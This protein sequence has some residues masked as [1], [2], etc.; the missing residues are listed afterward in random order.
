MKMP[1]KNRE[2]EAS[3]LQ[4]G[5]PY[6]DASAA[7]SDRHSNV[8]FTW[9]RPDASGIQELGVVIGWQGRSITGHLLSWT[10]TEDGVELP[11]SFVSRNYQPDRVLETNNSTDLELEVIA[12]FPV[13]NAIAIEFLLRNLSRER[14]SVEI[15]FEGPASDLLNWQGPF[16]VGEITLIENEA[17]GSWSTLFEHR[18]HGVQHKCSEEFVAG[19][20]HEAP[21]ELIC[22]SDL[23]PRQVKLDPSGSQKITIPMAFG[24]YRGEARGRYEACKKKTAGG[25]TSAEETERWTQLFDGLPPLPEKYRGEPQY[26]GLYRH[27]AAGLHSLFIQGDGGYTGDKRM[28]YTTKRGV[29]LGY[30]WDAAISCVG[31][32]EIDAPACQEAI[33]CFTENAGPRGSLPMVMCD[34]HRAGEGQA[35]VMCWGAWSTYQRSRDTEWLSRIYPALCGYIRFWL[36][37]HASERGLCRY[38]NAGQI[39]DNDARFDPIMKGRSNE[40]VYG[41]EAPDLNAF[42]VMEMNCLAEFAGE[43]DRP[44]EAKKWKAEASAL[45][46]RIVD[47]MYFPEDT[48]FYDVKEGTQSQFSGT[49]TPNMFLP[50]WAGVPLARDEIDKIV[51][52]HMLNPGEFYGE[53]PFP[54]LSYDHPEYDPDSLWR[55]RIWPHVNYWMVQTLWKH[56]YHREAEQVADQ[57]LEI[58]LANPWI[59]E[60]YESRQGKPIGQPEYNW[61]LSSA[62]QFLLERYKD[63][64]PSPT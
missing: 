18:M 52:N 60:S 38:F 16:P 28:L 6:T 35:P 12:A 59:H 54:S 61:S 20:S 37:Y 36:K 17:A 48:M 42:L 55:G 10:L 9:D 30:F 1:V 41:F 64:L 8:C 31:A 43:L 34:S 47:T 49:K 3:T 5:V 50:L 45:A 58:L 25:W 57:V 22:L 11:L 44:D 40:S 13:R 7:W 39:A 2:P 32:R 15:A 27:A 19:M 51:R 23:S 56:G 24:T 46:G 33:E 53:C 21:I 29:A 63:P 62:I 26:E 4:P 14:R